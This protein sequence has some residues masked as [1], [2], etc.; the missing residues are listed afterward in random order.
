ML[1]CLKNWKQYKKS[2]CYKQ[3]FYITYF[4]RAYCKAFS[5]CSGVSFK[6]NCMASSRFSSVFFLSSIALSPFVSGLCKSIVTWNL[7]KS[8]FLTQMRHIALVS[9][10]AMLVEYLEYSFFLSGIYKSRYIR[11]LPVINNQYFM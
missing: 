2:P 7:S 4:F 6:A 8:I 1:L 5:N 9:Y 11:S 3:G 10:A